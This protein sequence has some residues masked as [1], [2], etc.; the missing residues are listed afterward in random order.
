MMPEMNGIDTLECIR[1]LNGEQFRIL[2]VVSLTAN[3][4]NGAREMF[5][6][7]GFSDFISKPID[8]EK[9]EKT[10][11]TLLPAQMIHYTNE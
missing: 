11:K 2:P 9:M 6:D 7:A 3:V 8:I 4:V 10:L 1:K 5:L